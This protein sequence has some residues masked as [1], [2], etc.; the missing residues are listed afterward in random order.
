MLKECC[1]PRYRKSDYPDKKNPTSTSTSTSREALFDKGYG[2]P[3]LGL[4]LGLV[5]VLW[6][7]ESKST[8]KTAFADKLKR[9][10]ACSSRDQS[11]EV[12]FVW[13][14]M[15]GITRKGDRLWEIGASWA[16]AHRGRSGYLDSL[17]SGTERFNHQMLENQEARLVGAVAGAGRGS[18]RK[19]DKTRRI[20]I[21]TT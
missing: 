3:G 11:Q 14:A 12:E 7:D 8:R 13:V 1:V 17:R 5:N 21:Q 20:L 9:W 6:D 2:V 18:A 10:A 16:G 19:K 4:E 15:L